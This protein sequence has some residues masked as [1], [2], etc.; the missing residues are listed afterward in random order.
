MPAVISLFF[1]LNVGNNLSFFGIETF[2]GICKV[3]E[4]LLFSISNFASF[5][6][7]FLYVDYYVL[8]A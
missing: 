6:K 3:Q 7:L 2:I 5:L 8:F 1:K 4:I